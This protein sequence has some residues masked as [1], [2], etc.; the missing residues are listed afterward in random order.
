MSWQTDFATGSGGVLSAPTTLLAVQTIG[1]M[2]TLVWC[3]WICVSAYKDFGES[4]ITGM[5]LIVTACRAVGVF[6]VL[7]YII[8]RT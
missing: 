2:L 3:V 4:Q 7:S 8:V 6:V 5:D 1:A